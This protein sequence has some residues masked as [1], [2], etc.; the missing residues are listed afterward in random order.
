MK[1]IAQNI[2]AVVLALVSFTDI[3]NAQLRI[4]KSKAGSS[5]IYGDM[6]ANP[7]GD[8]SLAEMRVSQDALQAFSHS[9]QDAS[10]AKWYRLEKF[11]LVY[12]TKNEQENKALYDIKGNLKYSISYGTV[13]DLP[14]DIRKMVKRQY[15]EYNILQVIEVNEDSRNIW[16]INLDDDYD[17]ITA[18]VENV[19]IE[20]MARYQ[21][22]KAQE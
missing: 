2:L 16:I 8:G 21:K 18:R 7:S 22:S 1:H 9:F 15:I 10:N 13:K 19:D 6:L 12:F 11:Y 5:F 14:N 20:E 4:H 17:L 3:S